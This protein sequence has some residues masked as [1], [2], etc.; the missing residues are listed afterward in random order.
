[1]MTIKRLSQA[2]LVLVLAAGVSYAFAQAKPAP[3]KPAPVAAAAAPADACGNCEACKAAG[4]PGMMGNGMHD[5]AMMR[6]MPKADVTV[7]NTKQGAVIRLQTKNAAE[8][9]KIQEM[10]QMMAKHLGGTCEMAGEHG[11]HDKGGH[12]HHGAMH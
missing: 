10:A 9:A 3:T 5:C 1:M 2:G 6:D 7:E 8:V 4:K 12:D 11:E